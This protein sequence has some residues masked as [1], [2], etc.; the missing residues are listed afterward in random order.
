MSGLLAI[1]DHSD[2]SSVYREILKIIVEINLTPKDFELIHAPM[3]NLGVG[4]L[5]DETWSKGMHY[6]AMRLVQRFANTKSEKILAIEGIEALLSRITSEE[7]PM[8]NAASKVVLKI[9]KT[10]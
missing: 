9:Q 1:L 2:D 10:L 4:L 7:K 6:I 8:C 5:H 3:L